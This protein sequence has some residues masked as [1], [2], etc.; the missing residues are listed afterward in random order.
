MGWTKLEKDV[1][2]EAFEGL[3]EKTANEG[4]KG[5]GQFF[6][7]RPLIQAIIDVMKPDPTEMENFVIGDTS[8]GTGGFLTMALEWARK[9]VSNDKIKKISNNSYFGQE[10]VV[11]PYRLA[12]M[13]M[14]LHG[15]KAEI[16]LGDS[17]YINESPTD[18][19]NCIL[20]NPPFGTR[21]SI[22]PP[23][24]NFPVTTSN[25]QLNFIQHIHELLKEGGRAAIVLP[26]S[27]LSDTKAK[28]LWRLLIGNGLCNVHTILRLPNGTFNPYANGVKACVIFLEK[29]KK[30]EDVWVYDARS[31]VEDITKASRPLDY[32]KHF[33][34]FV[35][36][37]GTNPN[38]NSKR[39]ETTNFKKFTLKEIKEK[40]YDL[41]T[42]QIYQPQKLEEPVFYI[43][44]LI[45]NFEQQ[46][47]D[48]KT[49]KEILQ[50]KGNE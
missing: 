49:L 31:G 10:L 30:T 43:D 6:T 26:D 44:K 27:S 29:G 34:D 40:N 4:K 3:L 42:A 5:A 25:L 28:E 37:Y 16:K 17:I 2:G 14:F 36:S 47:N 46:L 7:P 20:T 24:R 18:K 22:G 38:G 32:N 48:L 21:G 33:G 15:V 35:N 13:N 39:V 41:S 45:V 12:L 50:T 23:N 19:L 8:C 1:Q 9:N 11:R